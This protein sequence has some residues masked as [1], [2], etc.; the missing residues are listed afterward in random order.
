MNL[1]RTNATPEWYNVTAADRNVWQRLAVATHGIATPGNA[2]TLLGLCLVLWGLGALLVGSYW[3]AGALVFA[4]RLCDLADGWA[5][6]A[7]KT[8]SPF[9]E[10]MDATADKIE[11]IAAV[12]AVLFAGL[13]PW[14]LALAVLAT[15]LLITAIAVMARRRKVALHPSR[16]GKIVMALIWVL[17]VGV[18]A[19]KAGQLSAS[20]TTILTLVAGVVT[21]ALIGIVAG[22]YARQL[23]AK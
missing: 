23:R 15:Q 19:L 6:E 1:H 9:G 4:G 20:L 13:L 10:I 11:T 5:A 14:W 21:V 7:T 17:L 3:L 2:F 22:E 12:I 8:K 16:Q 18:V